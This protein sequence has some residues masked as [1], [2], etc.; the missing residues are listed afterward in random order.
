MFKPGQ[1]AS[2]ACDM[3]CFQN[4]QYE[5]QTM[6]MCIGRKK[7]TDGDALLKEAMSAVAET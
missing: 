3:Y 1:A 2:Q 7:K 4:A 5:K 6:L